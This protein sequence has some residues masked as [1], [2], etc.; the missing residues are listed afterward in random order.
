MSSD[1]PGGPQ[2]S[3]LDSRIDRTVDSTAPFSTDASGLLVEPPRIVSGSPETLSEAFDVSADSVTTVDGSSAALIAAF[4]RALEQSDDDGFDLEVV[5]SDTSEIGEYLREAWDEPEDVVTSAVAQFW[6]AVGTD[7]TLDTH[8]DPRVE[9]S[10]V[11][12]TAFDIAERYPSIRR[13]AFGQSGAACSGRTS[14]CSPPAGVRRQIE[15]FLDHCLL[16]GRL[17][18]VD[19]DELVRLV[20]DIIHEGLA[21]PTI[22]SEPDRAAA[23]RRLRLALDALVIPSA[24]P[25]QT[26]YDTVADDYDDIYTDGLSQAEDEIAA[27]ELATQVDDGDRVL[28]LGC[29]SGL[30]Y[31]LLCDLGLDVEYIGVDISA[32]MVHEAREKHGEEAT[33]LVGDIANLATLESGSFDSVISLWGSFSHAFPN[34]QAIDEV[35]R[36]LVP[37]GT[38]TMLLYSRWSVGN[39]IDALLERS[40]TPIERVR[41]YTIRQTD[42]EVTSQARFYSV[43]SATRAFDRFAD[44]SVTGV[45]ALVELTPLESLF[46]DPDRS[47]LAKRVLRVEQ[48]LLDQVGASDAAHTLFVSGRKPEV[49]E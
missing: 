20:F 36:L 23:K 1:R 27:E 10:R 41:P 44:V 16:T 32:G 33:F 30:G 39:V 12:E 34:T 35:D 5:F 28:D 19:R 6:L 15:A 14:R 49:S 38:F 26:Y 7:L 29:G 25:N 9:L 47:G 43:E 8:G 4:K 42:S 2:S 24:D 17:A 48:A 22:Q 11:I 31:E 21:N 40:I 13:V 46:R 37:S 18:T 45:N 3:A